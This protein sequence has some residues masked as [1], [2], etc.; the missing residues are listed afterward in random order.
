MVEAP[1]FD[2]SAQADEVSVT[3]SKATTPA[4]MASGLSPSG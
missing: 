1:F 3:Q 2:S 4:R